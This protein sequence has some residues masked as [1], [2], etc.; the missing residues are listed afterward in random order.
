MTDIMDFNY[1]KLLLGDYIILMIIIEII[2]S[3]LSIIGLWKTFKKAGQPG[4]A[5]IIPIY[6]IIILLK[7]AKVNLLNLII[8]IMFSIL[9]GINNENLQLIGSLGI[10]I[11]DLVI[12]IKI[13]KAFNKSA[14]FGILLFL[15]PYLGYMILGFGS[16]TY[17]NN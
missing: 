10:M 2:V 9:T 13:T 4:W 17:N 16:A 3:F 11:Y 12:A 8:I 1:L 6:N 5:S 14:I 7:V 15:F